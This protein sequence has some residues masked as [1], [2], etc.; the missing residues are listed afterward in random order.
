[1]TS[2]HIEKPPP[3][4]MCG[5]A[6]DPGTGRAGM[7][8]F[9]VPGPPENHPEDE[10]YHPQR[11]FI[12]GEKMFHR[13]RASEIAAVA[14]EWQY[15]QVFETWIIDWHFSR[16]TPGNF[17]IS[18]HENFV[19]S[20]SALGMKNRQHG[21]NFEPGS[22]D[23]DGREYLLKEMLSPPSPKIRVLRHMTL[24]NAQME[25]LRSS[26]TDPNR[27]DKKA[28]ETELVDCLE[29][30]AGHF[31]H[32]LYW[33]KPEKVYGSEKDMGQEWL[34]KF[35]KWDWRLDGKKPAPATDPLW[36]DWL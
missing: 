1:M 35:R 9:G 16:Q 30:I 29:L 36:T 13:A 18:I 3:N 10:I 21:E 4:T 12:Y 28:S 20:F 27:R 8:A 2:G 24:L 14:H 19:R 25:E 11:L 23:V 33:K 22:Q 6:L 34:K 32:G 5:I 15:G 31:A 7:L 17:D 26:K